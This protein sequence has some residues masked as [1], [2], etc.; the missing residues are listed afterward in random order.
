M[1]YVHHENNV[2]DE[3]PRSLP[4]SWKNVS[5]LNLASPEMLKTLGWLPVVYVNEDYDPVLEVREGPTGCNV[6]DIVPS[7]A[8]EVTGTYAVRD[9]TAEE[10]RAARLH[11]TNYAPKIRRQ[12]AAM[13][14]TGD[15][16][17]ALLL[18]RQK[19]L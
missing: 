1:Q 12:A 19:G 16:V 13:E 5:G 9:K 11:I 6:G 7:G 2:I 15:T 4:S 10:L 17:G 3:G 8:D 14:A 18:L